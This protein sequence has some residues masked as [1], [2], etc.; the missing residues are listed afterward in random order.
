MEEEE[1]DEGKEMG[2][3]FCSS[4]LYRW[5][6]WGQTRIWLVLGLMGGICFDRKQVVYQ[7]NKSLSPYS[8]ELCVQCLDYWKKE[9]NN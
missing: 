8:Y 4:S 7:T 6:G 5:W 3:G 1:E 9:K 2:K